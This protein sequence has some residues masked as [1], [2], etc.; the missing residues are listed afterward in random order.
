[1]VKF[2]ELTDEEIE[3]ITGGVNWAIYGSCLMQHGASAIPALSE[4][5]TAVNNKNW[6]KVKVLS[7]KASIASL[8]IVAECLQSS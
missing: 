7:K 3:S 1:M 4:L 2:K 6:D 5:V 8:P